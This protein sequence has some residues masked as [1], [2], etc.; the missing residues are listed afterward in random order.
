M[1]KTTANYDWINTPPTEEEILANE[2]GSVYIPIGIIE[3]KLYRLDTHWGT[4]NFKFQLWVGKSGIMWAEGSL[5]LVVTYG[6]RTRRLVGTATV[7]VPADTD[8]D[9]PLVNSNFSASLK[10]LATAN[11]VKPIGLAMGQGLNDRLTI[12]TPQQKPSLNGKKKPD[13]VDMPADRGM[14]DKYNTAV[15]NSDQKAM[16]I[17]RKVFPQIQYTGIK[18]LTNA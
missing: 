7:I 1:R 2:D 6:G 11:A 10:S 12:N 3:T 17:I 14:Q 5:E 16:D 13:A 18:K 9:D 15:E 8:F 4:E